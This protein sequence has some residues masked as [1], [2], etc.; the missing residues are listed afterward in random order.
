MTRA[1]HDAQRALV[2]LSLMLSPKRCD[3]QF[4]ASRK[5]AKA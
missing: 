3:R 1:E 5:G 2:A 4:E